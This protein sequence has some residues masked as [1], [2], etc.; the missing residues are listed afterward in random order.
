MNTLQNAAVLMVTLLL[1][2]ACAGTSYGNVDAKTG[3]DT[4]RGVAGGNEF[5]ALAPTGREDEQANGK[6]APA[7]PK[8]APAAPPQPV[9]A[10][11]KGGDAAGTPAAAATLKSIAI[12]ASAF[13]AIFG[14]V[15]TPVQPT[16]EQLMQLDSLAM[17]ANDA[18]RV[19]LQRQILSCR[20]AGNS[21]RLA[22]AK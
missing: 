15:V 5:D 22:A 9:G 16:A 13:A 7:G 17:I 18:V 8:S 11:P 3:F 10:T 19:D 12:D 4:V 14:T 21:C 20:R 2:S 6:V 1:L